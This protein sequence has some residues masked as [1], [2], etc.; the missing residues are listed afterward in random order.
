MLDDAL[1]E[2]TAYF[3]QQELSDKDGGDMSLGDS[4]LNIGPVLADS[5]AMPPPKLVRKPSSFLGPTPK[6]LQMSFGARGVKQPSS[7]RS[8]SSKL[9]RSATAPGTTTTKSFPATGLRQ[10]PTSSPQAKVPERLKRTTSLP[11]MKVKNELPFYKRVGVIPRELK[12]SN[13]KPADNIKLEPEGRQVLRDKVVY[14]YPNNDTSMPRRM[15]IHKIIQLGAAWVRAWREDITHIMVDESYHTYSQV[16]RHLNKAGLP[17]REQRRIFLVK[18][19]PYVP[20]CIQFGTLL[21]PSAGRFLVKGAPIS[22]RTAVDTDHASQSSE[23]QGSL[24]VKPSLRQLTAHDSQTHST[25]TEN[26]PQNVNSDPSHP[27]GSSQ[28]IVKDSFIGDE[29]NESTDAYND[30]LSQAIQET[31]AI[32]HLPLDEEEEEGPTSSI[33]H[34]SDSGTDDEIP[35][36]PSK[37]LKLSTSTPAPPKGKSKGKGKAPSSTFQCMNPSGAASSANPNSRT[38]EILDQMCKYYDQMQDQWRTFAYRKA[39]ST[40]RKQ[41]T[42]ITTAKEAAVLPFI[43]QRLADKIEEIVLT[44]RLRRLDSTRDDPTDQVLRLFLGVYGA[45][46]AQASK[47]IQAG[48]RTLDDL[49][50]KAKL[51]S[52]QKIGIEHYSDFAQRIP[53]TEVE[54]H[55]TTIKSALRTLDPTFSA[56]IMGSYRRGAKDSGDIDIIITKPSASIAQLHSLVFKTLIPS[57]TSSGFLKCKLATSSRTDDGTKWH[58]VSCLPD[59]TTW[60]RLDL[61]LV[62]E[63]EMGAALLYFTGNDIFNRS[64]RLLA[65]K[66]GMRLNQRGLYRDVV[67]GRNREKLNEGTLVE[68]RSER[69]IFEILGVPWREPGERIC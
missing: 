13:A 15:R 42:K 23:S 21:D 41:D 47:W 59:S 50:T 9:E 53:R 25:P 39:I 56:T 58:G 36:P 38:I 18:F 61:L 35:E 66:K 54:A 63:E 60:R 68:G 1:R 43:G 44:D 49:T 5:E 6:E 8:E 31:K 26:S 29:P 64:I 12:K 27:P 20:Q 10:R 14:F 19:D 2:K 37:R 33:D 52:S 34:D 7:F 62:P 57:L 3:E 24:Q 17:C 48:Y 67:R 45:G 69:K 30:D 16:L 4:Y 40:L 65:S 28:E 51:T 22:N 32:A 55:G 46:L 11:D